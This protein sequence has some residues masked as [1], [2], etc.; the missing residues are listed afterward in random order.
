MAEVALQH[1]SKVYSNDVEAL[2]DFNLK[3][4]D[5]ELVVLLGPSECGKT[6]T[7][8]LIA[9]LEDL[10]AGTVSIGGHVVNGLPPRRRNVALVFQKSTLYPHLNVRRNIAFGLQLRQHNNPLVKLAL[11]LFR[12]HL[13]ARARQQEKQIGERVESTAR[14]L[15]LEDVLDRRP[16]QLS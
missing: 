11:R 7:L 10:T 8:R 15:G 4:A 14:L 12:L 5:G 16:S 9:G 2:R 1:L 13:Y 3:V 6:T